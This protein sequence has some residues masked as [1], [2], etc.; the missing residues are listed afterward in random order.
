MT[1]THPPQGRRLR[2]DL[3]AF[4]ETSPLVLFGLREVFGAA[5]VVYPE[6][7]SGQPGAP[8]FDVRVVSP[9]A[10]PFRC[11]DGVLVE[12]D[13]AIAE[14][15]GADIVVVCDMHR[16]IDSPPHGAFPEAA[17]WLR[18]RHAAGA[19]VCSVCSGALMLAEAGLLDGRE[20]ASHWAY[21]PMFR[22]HYPQVR[23]RKGLAL[24]PGDEAGRL[25]TTGAVMAWQDL[26]LY[27]I[28]RHFGPAQAIRTAKAYLFSR[29]SDGQLPYAVTTPWLQDGDALIRD[30]QVWIAANYAEANPVSRMIERSGLS[31]RGFA[32]RFRA[33]TGT[34]PIA[35]VQTVRVE[36][37]KQLL[38]TGRLTVDEV[39]HAV[40]YEDPAS[41]GRLFR[42][43]TGLSPAAYG[44]KFAALARMHA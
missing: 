19:Q 1:E 39:A 9:F 38:E 10:D 43:M 30:S 35:Y 37:A 23:L 44:R 40:G 15:G 25:V 24:C 12:P 34:A 42:R 4:P 2:L 28:A 26:A 29:H 18:D 8:L 3:L 6:V 21:A 36:E 13:R 16:P 5:G 32:R 20:A 41:F 22:R 27:L 31:E 14:A 11:H 7:T 17:A 33:A